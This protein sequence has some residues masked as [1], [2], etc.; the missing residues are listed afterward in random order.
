[1]PPPMPDVKLALSLIDRRDEV[2][3]VGFPYFGGV[4]NERFQHNDQGADVLLRNVPGQEAR[5]CRRGILCRDA[6]ST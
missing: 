2:V 6:C 4:V 1:M 5:A 3:P